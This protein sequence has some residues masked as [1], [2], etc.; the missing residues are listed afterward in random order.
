MNTA[1]PRRPPA[2]SRAAAHTA[3]AGQVC[4]LAHAQPSY[5]QPG[6][7]QPNQD[8]PDHGLPKRVELPPPAERVQRGM[9]GVDGGH[10]SGAPEVIRVLLAEDHL[11]VRA[12][13]CALLRSLDGVDVVA[14]ASE[15]GQALE[16]IAHSNPRPHIAILDISMGGMGGLEAAGRIS[17]EHPDVKVIILSMHASEEYVLQALRAGA[18]AYLLKEAGFDELEVA[19]RTV[20]RGEMYFSAAISRSDIDNYM[21]RV[22][23]SD[24]PASA[25]TPRQQEILRLLSQGLTAGQIAQKLSIS[26]KT[27]ETHR[28]QIM[29]RLNIFDLAGLVRYAIRV[30]LIDSR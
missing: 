7:E 8:Q 26:S 16:I 2:I 12:G 9:G 25:L 6:Y 11:L 18:S 15:G 29:S 20:A 22:G 13:I 30:G 14:Q 21:R 19:L 28:S 27:V 1:P 24:E 5:E 10:F 4:A 3:A 17:R 23:N